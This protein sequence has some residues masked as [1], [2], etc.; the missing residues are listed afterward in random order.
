MLNHESHGHLGHELGHHGHDKMRGPLQSLFVNAIVTQFFARIWMVV[1]AIAL[2]KIA[3]SM[4]LGARVKMMKDLREDL[5]EEQ[6]DALLD[7]IWRRARRKRLANCPVMPPCCS[8][9][10]HADK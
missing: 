1:S 5:S 9:E 10:A 8:P 6:R 2:M 3:S 7:D 4:A